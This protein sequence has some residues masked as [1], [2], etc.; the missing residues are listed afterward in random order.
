MATDEACGLWIE[1][2]IEEELDNQEEL[3]DIGINLVKEYTVKHILPFI[4]EIEKT[5]GVRPYYAKAI[6]THTVSPCGF[7]KAKRSEGFIYYFKSRNMVKIGFAVDVALRLRTIQ[8]MSPVPV[9]CLGF[10]SGS[11][12]DEGAIHRKFA[13]YRKHGEWFEYGDDIKKFVKEKT[14]GN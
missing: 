9:L 11:L 3:H 4:N 8:G 6:I 14:G 2:R 1:Q 7:V 5:T 12:K 13:K 10:H